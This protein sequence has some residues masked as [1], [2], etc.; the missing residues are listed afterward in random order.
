MHSRNKPI[1]KRWQV[2][3]S[4]TGLVLILAALIFSC[5][6]NDPSTP[7]GQ[8]DWYYESEF[9]ANPE[10]TAKPEQVVILDLPPGETAYQHN[11][12]PYEYPEGGGYFYGIPWGDPFISR[13]DILDR[14][15]SLL[16]TVERGDGG[17][18]LEMSPGDY[19]I[20]VYQDGANVPE[21]GSVAF[22]RKQ[23]LLDSE[24]GGDTPGLESTDQNSS[25][26]PVYPAFGTLYFIPESIHP[27]RYNLVAVH[28]VVKH[29]PEDLTLDVLKGV[30]T[31]AENPVFQQRRHLFSFEETSTARKT[32]GEYGDDMGTHVFHSWAFPDKTFY[33]GIWDCSIDD[34]YCPPSQSSPISG[35]AIMPM[36]VDSE[37]NHPVH[38]YGFSYDDD[39]TFECA[40]KDYDR[41]YVYLD[42][43]DDAQYNDYLY[44]DEFS[45]EDITYFSTDHR[46]CFYRD[47]SQ[48]SKADRNALKS[49]EVALF[50]GEG[51][52][53]VAV[54][55]NASFDQTTLIPLEQVRS[56]A[57]GLYSN[58]TIQFFDE[59][60]FGGNLI[61]TVGVNT[62][63]NLSLDGTDI[64][65]I[66][67]FTDAKY[68]L[69]SSKECPYCNLAGV[70]LSG[71]A[72]D[73]ADL[74]HGNLMNANMYQC[75]LKQAN[76]SEALLNGAKMQN[77]NL[78]GAS[79]LSASLNA[80]KD[81]NLAAADLSGAYLQNVNCKG[82]DLGG[83]KFVNASFHTNINGYNEDG[84]AQDSDNPPYTNNCASAEGA[85]MDA[86]DFSGA[87]VA[88]TDFSGTTG[89]GVNFYNAV[90]TG[91]I[92]KGAHL[93]WA[94]GSGSSS[95]FNSAF[96]EGSNFTSATVQSATF[97]SAYVDLGT[98]T[99]E[100]DVYFTIPANHTQFPGFSTPSPPGGTT[101]VKFPYS[102]ATVVPD[103]DSS[104]TCPDGSSG[105][106]SDAV[107]AEPLT[108]R[109]Q[110]AWQNSKGATKP[111]WCAKVDLFW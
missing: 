52:T 55:L 3:I 77:T 37:T 6:S 107:W 30:T 34:F 49:G 91:A 100:Y 23:I 81:L 45:G 66:R 26:Y 82:A 76:M 104:N 88:G 68:I 50:E 110:S 27:E 42:I 90:L 92:F 12:I 86:A 70:D 106:C 38:I 79:L 56:I 13:A 71:L 7:A 43:E 9:A 61:K 18:Y 94:G 83:V 101:C 20:Q 73:K 46:F 72:L 75:S 15:G 111:E 99:S 51:Y 63:K 69:I 28:D 85:T 97:E 36:Y 108:P 89:S 102:T 62:P 2:V 109:D 57:F 19:T 5:S 93:D 21:Q 11:G 105:P 22:I 60:D 40:V 39:Y 58:T 65:S 53:G 4:G 8:R 64:A 103:T 84:C 78:S 16:A 32:D 98:D 17:V 24:S 14:S 33:S 29:S 96:V 48:I 54:I 41:S 35:H 87:Y 1:L 67:I 47:G 80:D 10:L 31:S 74:T 44:F 25:L 95:T 59:P